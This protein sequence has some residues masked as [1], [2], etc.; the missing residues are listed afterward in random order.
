MLAR[1]TLKQFVSKDFTFMDLLPWSSSYQQSGPENTLVTFASNVTGI[2]ISLTKTLVTPLMAGFF[3]YDGKPLFFLVVFVAKP[4]SVH[5]NCFAHN[6]NQFPYM[7][8]KSTVSSTDLQLLSLA[9][10][11]F[12]ACWENKS[13][14]E[15]VEFTRHHSPGSSTTCKIQNHFCAFY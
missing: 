15:Q 6:V 13:V 12:R 2:T 11:V 3:F 5:I 8:E 4:T 10:W 14:I 9:C 1:C 7:M